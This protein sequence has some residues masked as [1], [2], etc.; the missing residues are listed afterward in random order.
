MADPSPFVIVEGKDLFGGKCPFI[1]D[2]IDTLYGVKPVPYAE[3]PK[4]CTC[5]APL[6]YSSDG[7]IFVN[8]QTEE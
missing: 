4:V 3:L 6:T 7:V 5:G 1:H 8:R 2:D